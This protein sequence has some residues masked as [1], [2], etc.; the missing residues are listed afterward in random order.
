MRSILCRRF[1]PGGLHV[2][3]SRDA[4]RRARRRVLVQHRRLSDDYNVVALDAAGHRRRGRARPVR[5]G[6]AADRATIPLLRRP[7]S[8][9]EMLRDATG[10]PTG[11]THPQQARRRAAR[12]CSSSCGRATRSPA[13]A[14]SAAPSSSSSRRQRGLDG[15]RRRRPGAVRH[16]R[17]APAR[18]RRPPAPVLRRPHAQRDLHCADVF[19]RPRR[20]RRR[21]PPRTA[22]AA[23]TGFVTVPLAR[24][25]GRPPARAV[26]VY[27]CGPTPMM[28]A[29]AELAPRATAAAATCRSNR[30]WAAASAAATAASSGCCDAGGQRHFVRSCVNGPDLRR[31]H[32]RVGRAGALMEPPGPLDHASGRCA[33]PTRSSP[34]AAASATATSTRTP[35]WWISPRSAP[36]S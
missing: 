30:S 34:R 29:V 26:R 11:I 16:A 7:F 1:Y 31:Q 4:G 15:G 2:Y 18:A 19:E 24:A 22:A 13:S 23:T 10:R 25:F 36:S 5:D 12:R 21:A 28:R 17:R 35:A 6:E 8:I 33:W 27:A 20:R 32:A 9:F 14:R 3:L